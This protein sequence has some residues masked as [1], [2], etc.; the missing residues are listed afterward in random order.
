MS[1]AAEERGQRAGDDAGAG[2]RLQNALGVGRSGQTRKI[3]GIRFEEERHEVGVII[4][5]D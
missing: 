5:R 1:V 4:V 2:G 3:G